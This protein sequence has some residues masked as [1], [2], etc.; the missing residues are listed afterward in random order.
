M[1]STNQCQVGNIFGPVYLWLMFI[2]NGIEIKYEGY[3][4]S[5]SYHKKLFVGAASSR[6]IK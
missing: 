3:P 6:E 4:E 2:K 5:S 1:Q